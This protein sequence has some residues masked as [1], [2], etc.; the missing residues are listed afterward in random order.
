MSN[1]DR[2]LI[3]AY[4]LVMADIAQEVGFEEE[5]QRTVLN[6]LSGRAYELTEIWPFYEI[7]SQLEEKEEE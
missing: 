3:D 2:K 6:V 5:V 1:P 4:E 7:V